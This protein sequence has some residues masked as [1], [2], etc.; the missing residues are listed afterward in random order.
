MSLQ[1]CIGGREDGGIRGV[2][3]PTTV[4]EGQ[5]NPF[6]SASS[7]CRNVPL[8]AAVAEAAGDHEACDDPSPLHSP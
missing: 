6:V 2:M 4:E 3:D 8:F 7:A 5:P 1:E